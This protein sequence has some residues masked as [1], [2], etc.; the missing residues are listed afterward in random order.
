MDAHRIASYL[1]HHLYEAVTDHILRSIPLA[2]SEDQEQ[3]DCPL[4]PCKR[5]FSAAEHNFSLRIKIYSTVRRHI[6]IVSAKRGSTRF[7]K[8]H[9]IAVV[10][11]AVKICVGVDN[12][13]SGMIYDYEL[14]FIRRSERL[15]LIFSVCAEHNDILAVREMYK[16]RHTA[17]SARKKGRK[18][19]V[20]QSEPALG[21][22]INNNYH[23]I[24]RSRYKKKKTRI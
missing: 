22:I 9:E 16:F 5:N 6:G 21:V 13:L 12:I 3:N 20:S 11:F 18:S 8:L 1:R 2:H 7:K 15:K 23:N 24:L 4:E 14:G 19:R 17:E 10:F